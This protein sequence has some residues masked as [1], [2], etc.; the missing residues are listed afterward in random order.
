MGQ[1]RAGQSE[2]APSPTE[3]IAVTAA[4]R[5]PR[6]KIC[7]ITNETDGLAAARLGVD[8]IGFIFYPPSPRYVTPERAAEVLRAMRETCGPAAPRA[9]GVFVDTSPGD[10][11]RVRRIARL[12]GTQFSGDEPPATVAAVQPLR[13]RSLSLE[14]L[15]RFGRYDVD[16]YLCDA[17][18]PLEKGG[19]GRTY[20]Y[21]RLRPYAAEFPLMVA[22]GLTPET[23]GQVVA[24]LRPWGVDVSSAL[25]AKPGVKD[26]ARMR[27][28]VEAVRNETGL[29]A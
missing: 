26:H 5:T 20:D 2:S 28:F 12:D 11:A 6:I 9:I 7:G 27:A 21:D 15:D 25:E 13:I 1:G 18:A 23:V 3:R 17:H 8:F 19:T 16:A 29:K 14:T 10:I 4:E 22:G 24:S